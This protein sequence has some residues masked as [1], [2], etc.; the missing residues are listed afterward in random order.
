MVH[1]INK[2][3]FINSVLKGKKQGTPQKE[4]RKE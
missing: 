4:K 3:V 2:N 1:K